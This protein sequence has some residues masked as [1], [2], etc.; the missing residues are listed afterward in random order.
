MRPPRFP[1][2]LAMMCA[3]AASF[4]MSPVAA[5]E[6]RE[7][8]IGP[9]YEIREPDILEEILAKLRQ[10]E[11]SGELLRLQKEAAERA[12]ARILNPPPVA[13]IT[14]AKRNRVTYYDPTVVAHEDIT[15]PDGRIVVPRGT[16]ANPLDMQDFGDPMLFFDARDN[17]Q[18]KKA[19]ALVNRFKGAIMPVLTGGSF[20]DLTKEWRR[21]VYYDQT[22]FITQKLGITH[23]PALVTQEGNRLRI[24]EF[25]M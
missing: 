7:T 18:V 11:K 10:K 19:L 23:V 24:E 17:R 12:K 20:V 3:M 5:A 2:F 1:A 16:R 21:K 9:T 6:E 14:T 15:S 13:G 8:V 4:H 22:G 25:A